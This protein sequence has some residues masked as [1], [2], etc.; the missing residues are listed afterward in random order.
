MRNT[1]VKTLLAVSISFAS[2]P[3]TAGGMP[4]VDFAAIGRAIASETA[5]WGQTATMIQ[6]QVNMYANA[7]QN[8]LSLRDTAFAPL[9]NTLR[10]VY[11]VYMQGQSLMWRAQNLD[12]AFG[13]MYPSYQNYLYT[14]GQGGQTMSG[15]YRQW[16]DQGN[17]SVRTALTA[18]GIQVNSMDSDDVMLQKL[19]L[20]S[21]TA[22]GQKGALQ[23]GNEIAALNVQQMQ[24]LQSL[25]ST[26]LEMQANYIAL[27]NQR[28]TVEDAWRQQF[29][30]RR[31][32]NSPDGGL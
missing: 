22:A 23:A 5:R 28:Q 24:R 18:A 15:L 30:V 3:A 6:N 8:T 9:G 2:L 4:V 12:S 16:S 21:A 26:Q 31:P 1:L 25:V 11:G 13:I 19:M 17:Q 20:R 29:K 32:T 27:Q 10:S 14:M 7:V